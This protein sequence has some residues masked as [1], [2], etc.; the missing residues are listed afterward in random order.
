MRRFILITGASSGI[1]ES[2][3]IALVARGYEVIAGVRT[4]QD[5]LRLAEV[6]KSK[7]HPLIMDVTDR[8]GMEKALEA[9]VHIIDDGALVA[10]FN[11]AGIVVNGPILYVPPEE[12]Q[13]QFEVNV[14]GLVRTTQLFFPLLVKPKQTGDD[15]PRRIINMSS[16]SGVFASPFIGAYAASKYAVE[17]I[18]DSL[19]R[20]LYMYDVQV[21]LIQ[22]GNI[23][24]PIWEKAR[25]TSSYLGP[26]Y[27][28]IRAFKDKMLDDLIARG[29]PVSAIDEVI[30]KAVTQ[31]AVKVRYLI[32]PQKWKFQLIRLLPAKWID[33]MIAKKLRD[34]SGIR[35]F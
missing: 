13:K 20:E 23:A 10:I 9:T 7:I 21:V 32:R 17:A 31:K 19:R 8:A 28:S 35:P 15:H 29:M 34:R 6:G 2:A 22:A 24:T 33:R 14:T 26:E 18:S 25:T 16:V 4:Q 5:A 1:G 27:E 30:I 12:W 11:N 3:C